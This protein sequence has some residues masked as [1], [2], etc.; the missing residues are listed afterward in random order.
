MLDLILIGSAMAAGAP[1]TVEANLA[2]VSDYRFRGV[3]MSDETLALQ[4]GFDA[5]FGDSGVYAGAWGSSIEPVGNSELELDLYIGRTFG[6][7]VV[8]FDVGLLAYTYPGAPDTAYG[9]VYASAT[10]AAG[11]GA[12]TFGAAYAPEQDNLGGE[13]NTYFSVSAEF[14]LADSGLTFNAGAGW[15]SG[16]FG[17]PDGDGEGKIDWT[18][19][20]TRSFDAFDISLSYVDTSEAGDASDSTVMLMLRRAF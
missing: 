14:P 4:G 3:S 7:E 6:G 20:V 9:E 13:D 2:M 19:G 16:A 12:V 15:E 18:A 10:L 1:I 5:V 17:D 11:A 8:R